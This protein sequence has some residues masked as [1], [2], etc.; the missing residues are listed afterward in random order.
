MKLAF[1]YHIPVAAKKEGL[2][3]PGYIGV[4]VDELARNVNKLYLVMHET[5]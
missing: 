5:T 1:Y 2:F 3:L 4:F